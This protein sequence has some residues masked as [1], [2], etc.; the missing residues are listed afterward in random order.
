MRRAG[1]HCW[2]KHRFVAAPL[3]KAS[4]P[5]SQVIPSSGSD[6]FKRPL[7]CPTKAHAEPP[8]LVIPSV[9]GDD[10]FRLSHQRHRLSSCAK[11]RPLSSPATRLSMTGSRVTLPFVISSEAEGSAVLLSLPSQ[12]S[13]QQPPSPFVI[14]PKPRDLQFPL[15][16]PQTTSHLLAFPCEANFR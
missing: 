16:L 9:P 10:S 3:E 7:L 11:T 12:V 1:C 14:P 5:S 6:C 13:P 2:K 8:F 4:R 15:S